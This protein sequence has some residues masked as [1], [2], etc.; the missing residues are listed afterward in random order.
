MFKNRI[1][2]YLYKLDREMNYQYHAN[3]DANV[4]NET[5]MKI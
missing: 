1:G 4:S 2:L 5:L 3:T